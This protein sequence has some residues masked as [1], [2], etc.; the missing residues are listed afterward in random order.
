M[1]KCHLLI[2]AANHQ[3]IKPPQLI[4]SRADSKCSVGSLDSLFLPEDT[5]EK[6]AAYQSKPVQWKQ[7]WSCLGHQNYMAGRTVKNYLLYF[8]NTGKCPQSQ[9]ILF[10][11]FKWVTE[12]WSIWNIPKNSDKFFF[13]W[14]C[15]E[16]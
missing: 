5:N 14:K 15:F 13:T 4:S 16:K 1:I 7:Y 2:S 11:F 6:N 12:V 3:P 8:S 10:W 9:S